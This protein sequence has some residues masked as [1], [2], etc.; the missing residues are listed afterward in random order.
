MEH[1]LAVIVLGTEDSIERGRVS[2]L[3]AKYALEVFQ[4]GTDKTGI[5]VQSQNMPVH[6]EAVVDRILR[7]ARKR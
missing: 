3:L 5:T 4:S 7:I 1:D 2:G 6:A